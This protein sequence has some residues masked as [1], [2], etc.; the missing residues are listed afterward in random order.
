MNS[1]ARK[2]AK[3]GFVAFSISYRLAPVHRFPAQIEDCKEAVRW[4]RRNAVQYKIEPRKIASWGFSAG[5]Q[6][7][8]LL[9]TLSTDESASVQAV[10]GGSGPYDLTRFP[11][12]ETT[13]K[14]LGDT[15]EGNLEIYR[16]ASPVFHVS[17]STPPMFL[18]HGTADTTVSPQHT[19]EMKKELDRAGVRNEI[20][21]VKGFG[22][23]MLFLFSW[24]AEQSGIEFLRGVLQ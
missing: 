13:V 20:Y 21:L 16:Q 9:G 6:L 5:A 24:G 12:D 7:A 10:V 17:T 18:Y 23:I 15:R 19:D 3:Q 1:V 22:H 2:L 11:S 4:M 14:F 8:V